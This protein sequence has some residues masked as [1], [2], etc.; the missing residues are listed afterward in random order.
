MEAQT[1]TADLKPNIKYATDNFKYRQMR[2]F[3]SYVQAEK[4]S[5]CN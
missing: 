2:I 1:Q 3:R 5:H 4:M